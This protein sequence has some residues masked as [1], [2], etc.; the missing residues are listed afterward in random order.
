M[1]L[2]LVPESAAH[3]ARLCEFCPKMCRFSC[4]VSEAARSETVTPWGKM[5]MLALT[6]ASGH[7]PADP[8]EA[9]ALY[10]CSGCLRCRDYCAHGNDVPAA[11]YAGRAVAVRAGVAPAYLRQRSKRT[12]IFLLNLQLILFFGK[13]LAL[14]SRCITYRR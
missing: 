13:V 1:P 3:A 12:T 7:P 8:E 9:R 6:S 10:A 4:P 11:L 14:L 2:S 5:T